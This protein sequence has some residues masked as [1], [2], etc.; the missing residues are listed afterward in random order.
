MLACFQEQRAEKAAE[1]DIHTEYARQREHMESTVSS[2]RKK[3]AKDN[4]IHHGQRIRVMQVKNCIN[5]ECI[6][7]C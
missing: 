3:L 2:L 1:T 4:D 7:A 5:Y 6:L